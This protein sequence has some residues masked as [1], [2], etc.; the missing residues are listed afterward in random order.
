M[1]FADRY[2][3]WAVIAGASDGTG[4]AFSH[5]IAAEGV[6]CILIARRSGPLEEAAA[7]LRA[8][9]GVE[10]VTASIDLAKPDASDRIIEAVG[11]REVGL[12]ISNAGA[13]PNGSHFLNKDVGTWMDLVTRNVITTM[14][15]CHH[16]APAMKARGKGGL[17]LVNSGACYGGGSFMACY[18]AS[19][20]FDLCF[21]ESLWGELHG[22]GVDMCTLVM[23]M[24]DTPAFRK[25]L[26]EKGLPFPDQVASPVDVA[27]TGLARLPHGPVHNMGL[28]DDELGF[29]PNSAAQR[30]ER[31]LTIDKM[32][33][34]VFGND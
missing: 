16:F 9:Y 26:T 25:L 27:R 10:C 7:D 15:C 21:A 23:G 17:L 20:A 18:T 22:Y 31:V 3:P 1:R 33:V 8:K 32:S 5:E 34:H 29:A 11:G 28:A 6:N 14:R 13:D 30:R 24:T 19:K 12:Y 2:G 4:L